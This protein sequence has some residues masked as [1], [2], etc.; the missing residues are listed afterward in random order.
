MLAE[1]C[2]PLK[3][4]VVAACPRQYSLSPPGV[5]RGDDRAGQQIF[6]QGCPSHVNGTQ[7]PEWRVVYA[8]CAQSVIAGGRSGHPPPGRGALVERA[9]GRLPS[10]SCS[11]G[12]GRRPVFFWG[13]L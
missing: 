4:F 8:N 11:P 6:P 2:G 7:V 3:A 10:P 1:S 9:V 5:S 13:R 12:G